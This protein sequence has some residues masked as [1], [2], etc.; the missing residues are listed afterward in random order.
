MLIIFNKYEDKEI[1]IMLDSFFILVIKLFSSISFIFLVLCSLFSH[2]II[3][4][5]LYL[6][7]LKSRVIFLNLMNFYQ[8]IGLTVYFVSLI[9]IIPFIFPLI[10]SLFLCYFYFTL[11]Y[12]SIHYCLFAF[13][14]FCFI[15]KKVIKLLS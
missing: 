11:K 12:Y 7:P 15:Y 8:F 10:D 13:F 1:Q 6:F 14:E 2:E 3:L 5:L 4:S 9:F